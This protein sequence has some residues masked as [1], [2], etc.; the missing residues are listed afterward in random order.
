MR[1]RIPLL[2]QLVL[3][4]AALFLLLFSLYVNSSINRQVVKLEQ[5]VA[6]L[7]QDKL[8]LH[9]SYDKMR[10]VS[11]QEVELQNVLLVEQHTNGEIPHIRAKVLR[12][13]LDLPALIAGTADVLTGLRR[14]YLEQPELHFYGRDLPFTR[15]GQSGGGTSPEGKNPPLLLQEL[16]P[17]FVL[18]VTGGRLHW[19]TEKPDLQNDRIPVPVVSWKI[20]RLSLQLSNYYGNFRLES[21]VSV[22]EEM[23]LFQSGIK[24]T[25]LFALKEQT[26]QL[27][28]AVD[29]LI[30]GG[31]ELPPLRFFASYQNGRMEFGSAPFRQLIK[32]QGSWEPGKQ[33]RI[34]LQ[35]DPATGLFTAGQ[36]RKRRRSYNKAY[37]FFSD[38]DYQPYGSINVAINGK[39]VQYKGGVFVREKNGKDVFRF[40]LLGSDEAVIIREFKLQ[41]GKRVLAAAGQWIF[42]R[43]FPGLQL[44][45]RNLPFMNSDFSGDLSLQ[46]LHNGGNRF[47]LRNLSI[48]GAR[49]GTIAALLYP[50]RHGGYRVLS[51]GL[52]GN[53]TI[54]G[55]FL[56]GRDFD[57]N[58]TLRNIG[59]AAPDNLVGFG[60]IFAAYGI[61]G[62][63]QLRTV[64]GQPQLGGRL[65]FSNPA[66]A[67]DF[68]LVKT[69]F[70]D[71]KLSLR[72]FFVNGL[73]L[74]LKGNIFLEPDSGK[75]E[76][77]MAYAGRVFPVSGNYI[78]KAD[79]LEFEAAIGNIAVFR[80]EF[81]KPQTRMALNLN[82]FPVS[83]FGFPGAVSTSLEISYGQKP[84]Q[85]AG[86]FRFDH[87][88]PG[89]GLLDRLSCAVGINGNLIRLG[90]LKLE[91]S[92]RE[93]TGNGYLR[94]GGNG[95]S[96]SLSMAKS[97]KALL[98]MAGGKLSGSLQVDGFNAADY[99]GTA[100]SGVLNT[101]VK[102][103][104]TLQKPLL[105]G[106]I[107]LKKGEVNGTPLAV[108]LQ[109]KSTA[110]G[111]ALVNSRFSWSGF[112]F[113]NLNGKIEMFRNDKRPFLLSGR[114]L[115]PQGMLKITA[116][117]QLSGSMDR[118]GGARALIT[119]PA[120]IINGARQNKFSVLANYRDGV[121][122][123]VRRAAGGIS[124]FYNFDSGVF[125]ARLYRNS[126]L[127]LQG[128]SRQSVE[129]KEVYLSSGENPLQLLELFPSVFKNVRS[130]GLIR[131]QLVQQ[132][133]AVSVQGN[134]SVTDGSFSTPLL[135]EPIKQ[136]KIKLQLNENR[137]VLQ[138]FSGTSGDGQLAVNGY[139]YLRNGRLDDMNFRLRSD[140]K[141]GL[142]LN[143]LSSEVRLVGKVLLDLFFKGDLR[144][145]LL[146]GRIAVKDMEFYYLP[147]GSPAGPETLLDR[148]N[149]DVEITVLDNVSYQNSLVTAWLQPQSVIRF[150][151]RMKDRDFLISGK[152]NFVRG[153]IEY[154]NHQFR[155]EQPT[156]LDF[157]RRGE[158]FDPWLTFK[159][160]TTVKDENLESLDIFMTF[161][162]SLSGT[163]KPEFYSEPARTE[164]EIKL[165][166]GLE[167]QYDESGQAVQQNNLIKQSSELL[168]LL[169]LRPV[170]QVIKNKLKL[171]LFSIRTPLVRNLLEG[172]S[173]NPAVFRDTQ[174]SLGKYLTSFLFVEYTLTLKESADKLGDLLP[175]HQLGLEFDLSFI[176]FGYFL[177]PTEQSSY[178]DYEHSIQ[179]RFRRRF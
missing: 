57:F 162:G 132:G 127:L 124:G 135:K 89:N 151:N 16:P 7:V 106:T 123:L 83:P 21:H 43:S 58:L 101:R 142:S 15:T 35:V 6:D 40:R 47:V 31:V 157:K 148:I 111:N 121:L 155:I 118:S 9:L 116:P 51:D 52:A 44:R 158:G 76:L 131:L 166:L 110:A 59:A 103:S 178:K 80:S 77:Q 143:M 79:S 177:A 48:D 10:F 71:G 173:L 109:L 45:F 115:L 46:R 170:S 154:I 172:E 28:L 139:A 50:H 41:Q 134:V 129:G 87:N 165:L 130:S 112:R 125:S 30:M 3:I 49:L 140:R 159:G 128:G 70:S 168:T 175:A 64:D 2:D 14:F 42:S 86:W 138:N 147:D 4:A 88:R 171:D 108:Q 149:W 102:V 92:G 179:L 105:D 66:N 19:Y 11:F 85:A 18:S 150:K 32:L 73:K 68:I 137:L 29:N 27:Q 23:E 63:M 75:L 12:V 156:F 33:G 144:Q 62:D 152:V 8:Q 67:D 82:N 104:G 55:R 24:L 93:L 146:Q 61:S 54:N 17:D 153:S 13:K 141:N 39:K 145:P 169:G 176:N 81:G 133:E 5:K 164:K 25:G 20:D 98:T 167:T 72:R 65:Q 96:A 114:F 36:R 91:N 84:L 113:D 38:R 119:L 161:N 78:Q 174:F 94:I 163:I 160:K 74:N 100:Y 37:F 122:Q 99:F 117:F 60:G 1:L 120:A 107:A 136:L 34:S 97:I 90:G 126:K 26:L 22:M 53:L 56:H 95:V 69:A